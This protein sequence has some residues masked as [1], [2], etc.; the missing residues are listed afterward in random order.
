[1]LSTFGRKAIIGAAAA[2]LW[3]CGGALASPQGE[4]PL[5]IKLPKPGYAGTPKDIPAGSTAEKP[6]GKPRPIPMVP[7]GTTN[8]A[9][10]KRVTIAPPP[11]NRKSAIFSGSL[12]QITD[13]DKEAREESQVELIPGKRWIQIDLGAPHK[14]FY[15][16]VWHSHTEAVIYRRVAVQVSDDPDFITG[17]TTLFNNDQLNDLGLGIGR[18]REYFESYEGKLI[19]AKG[20]TARYVRLWSM[21]N[22]SDRMNRYTEVEVWGL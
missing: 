19:D 2:L 13:G 8:L 16:V 7:A 14:L 5:P 18:D 1:M 6:T 21:G 17:V 3:T 9:L 10:H 11:P 22:T 4:V 15:I 12:E 20:I